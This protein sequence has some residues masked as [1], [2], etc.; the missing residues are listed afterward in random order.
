MCATS[1]NPIDLKIRSGS[2]RNF[3]PQT[4][5]V[6]LGRDLAGTVQSVG[7]GVSGFAVGNR[8]M[9]LVWR[10]YAELVATKAADLG[11][12]PEGL[13]FVQAG[14]MP[15]VATTG[16]QLIEKAGQVIKG[17]RV[18][19]TGA[20]GSVGRTAVFVAKQHGA[21]VIAGVRRSQLDEARALGADELVALDDEAA[22][23][24]LSPFDVLA[25]TVGHEPTLKLLPKIR[26]G[27][28][29]ASVVGS[30]P[31]A[32]A[33]NIRIAAILTQPDPARLRQL[34]DDVVRRRFELPVGRVLKLAEIQEAHRLAEKGGSGKL[35]IVP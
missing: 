15:L 22:L 13:E 29:L 5:P 24:A 28:T 9:G 2:A 35:V 14:A 7:A 26:D 6:I 23:Q 3:I 21:T 17:M 25:D 4:F 12:M 18:L 30:P 8:V 27:G 20:L 16:A 31:E 33:R 34:A 32:K 11:L 10:T 19:V 1:I